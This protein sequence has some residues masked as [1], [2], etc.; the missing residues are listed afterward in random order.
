MKLQSVIELEVERFFP[1]VDYGHYHHCSSVKQSRVMA[2]VFVPCVVIKS[3]VKGVK[4]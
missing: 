3:L 1:Q 4:S 2:K